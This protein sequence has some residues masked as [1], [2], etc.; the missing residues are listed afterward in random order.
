M[1]CRVFDTRNERTSPA[2]RDREMLAAAFDIHEFS[3][4]F[5]LAE[6]P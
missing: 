4:N 1:G 5:V 3:V 2:I 6:F